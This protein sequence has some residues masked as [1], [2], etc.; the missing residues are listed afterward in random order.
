MASYESVVQGLSNVYAYYPLIAKTDS[1][2][3]T[4]GADFGPNLLHCVDHDNLTTISGPLGAERAVT[5][6]GTN[7]MLRLPDDFGPGL[8]GATSITIAGY[9]KH[10]RNNT[11]RVFFYVPNSSDEDGIFCGVDINNYLYGQIRPATG[12][13]WRNGNSSTTQIADDT[14]EFFCIIYNISGDNIRVQLGDGSLKT[15]SASFT[16]TSTAFGPPNNANP[17]LLAR[18]EPGESPSL[19]AYSDGGLAHLV[20][21]KDA[22]VTVDIDALKNATTGLDTEASVGSNTGTVSLTLRG[23]DRNI[24][25]SKTGL[26]WAWFDQAQPNSFAAVV[27][28]GSDA[29]TNSSGV[30]SLTINNT[31]LSDGQTGFLV[32]SDTDGDAANQSIA[33][34]APVEISVS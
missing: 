25:S 20:I 23:P 34:A 28:T 16:A 21:V 29:S 19:D 8:D 13:T 2:L 31:S 6:N 30:L 18:N 33:F 1:G 9:H 22:L 7:S 32:V 15:N 14:W 17:H 3:W 4:V 5:G 27:A 10:A 26:R 12:E 24:L 11:Y